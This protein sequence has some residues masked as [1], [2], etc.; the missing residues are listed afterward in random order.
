MVAVSLHA[1]E[2]WSERAEPCNFC[3][4]SAWRTA[5]TVDG[6]HGHD[7]DE[8]RYHELTGTVL[9]RQGSVIVTV[10][11]LEEAITP[12]REAVAELRGDQA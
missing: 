3:P 7:A 6:D 9:V 11:V 12:L 4:A 5:V 2:R 8:L 10:L 1:E